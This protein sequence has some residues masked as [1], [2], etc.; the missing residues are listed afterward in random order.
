LHQVEKQGQLHTNNNNN[1]KKKKKKKK[2]KIPARSDVGWA[3]DL[4]VSLTQNIFSIRRKLH[5]SVSS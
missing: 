4:A 5:G 1:K 3:I 2:K